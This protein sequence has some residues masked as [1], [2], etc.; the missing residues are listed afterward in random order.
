MWKKESFADPQQVKQGHQGCWASRSSG[1]RRAKELLAQ[2]GDLARRRFLDGDGSNLP[3]KDGFD[4]MMLNIPRNLRR[5]S[6]TSNDMSCLHI[7]FCLC[8]EPTG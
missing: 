3:A 2:C 1:S 6:T 5:W 8:K 4:N 7:E